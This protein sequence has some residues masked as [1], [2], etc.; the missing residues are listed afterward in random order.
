M[1]CQ[2]QKVLLCYEIV[3]GIILMTFIS[4]AVSELLVNKLSLV[5]NEIPF[6]LHLHFYCKYSF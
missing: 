2:F 4:D 1:L 3:I 6:D 5:F